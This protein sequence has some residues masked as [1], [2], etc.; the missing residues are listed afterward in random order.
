M[1][2]SQSEEQ[3]S[4]LVFF[5]INKDFLK[6]MKRERGADTFCN[7]VINELAEKNPKELN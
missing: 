2:C 6:K 7:K 4:N 1:K 3:L 5:S